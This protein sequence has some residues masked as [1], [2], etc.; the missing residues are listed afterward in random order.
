MKQK[1]KTHIINVFKGL[2]HLLRRNIGLKIAAVL[3]ACILWSFVLASADPVREKSFVGTKVALENL[4][5]LE[6]QGLTLSEPDRLKEL[7]ARVVV[8]A[9]NR[10]LVSISRSQV[11]ASIDFSGVLE[12]GTHKLKVEAVTPTGTVRRI[13]PGTVDV[14]VEK[15][16]EKEIQ[17]RP[18]VVEEDENSPLWRS[19]AQLDPQKV[20]ISGPRSQVEQVAYARVVVP[21]E[22]EESGE[23]EIH[24]RIPLQLCDENDHLLDLPQVKVSDERVVVVQS[25]LGKKELEVEVMV[26]AGTRP[27]IG[28]EIKDYIL[29]EDYRTVTV[30]APKHVLDTLTTVRTEYIDVS[31]ISKD[32][33][34]EVQLVFPNGVTWMSRQSVNVTIQVGELEETARFTGVSVRSVTGDERLTENPEIQKITVQLTGPRSAVRAVNAGMLDFYVDVS[35]LGWGNSDNLTLFWDWVDGTRPQYSD[36]IQIDVPKTIRVTRR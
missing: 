21:E 5:I 12:E 7:T 11:T 26:K 31:G 6:E 36:Q 35:S 20:I 24:E 25:V 13:T 16:A 18:Q 19:E 8:Q 15:L 1:T 9:R 29:E 17:V 32:A 30:A 28:Y 33:R 2:G 23:E 22:P 34:R 3:F 10:Q 4:S 27:A 14:V